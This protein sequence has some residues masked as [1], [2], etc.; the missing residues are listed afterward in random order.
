MALLHISTPGA[1]STIITLD[2][3]I[4]LDITTAFSGDYL[5]LHLTTLIVVL[6]S[7]LLR[8]S[9]GSNVFFALESGF[10]VPSTSFNDAFVIVWDTGICPI[11]KTTFNAG[12][13]FT[14]DDGG[15]ITQVIGDSVDMLLGTRVGA[16]I[17]TARVVPEMGT[18]SAILG[19]VALL[20][21]YVCRSRFKKTLTL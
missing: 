20:S 4:Q 17:G 21:I 6:P 19:A 8:P 3:T 15:F 5:G 16:I 9:V 7:V 2:K 10:S 18:S 14:I 13:V 12:T 1:S 11:G